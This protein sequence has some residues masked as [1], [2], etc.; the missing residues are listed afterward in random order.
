MHLDKNRKLQGNHSSHGLLRS[1][2]E[3]IVISTPSYEESF[4]TVSH[5][6]VVAEPSVLG[7]LTE[8]WSSVRSICA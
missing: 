1:C 3:M 4:I 7:M 6:E 8:G 2:G 5:V